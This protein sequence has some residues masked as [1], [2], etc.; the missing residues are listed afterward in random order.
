[1]AVGIVGRRGR[2][3][4]ASLSTG[5]ELLLFTLDPAAAARASADGVDGIVV[6]WESVGKP[7]RQAGAD[8]Q[9]EPGSVDDLAAVRAATR[10]RVLCRVNG[11]GSWT[12]D[13]VEG[14]IDAGADELLLPMVRTVEEAAAFVELVGGRCSAGLLVETSAAVD[15][16]PELARLPLSRVYVGLNDLAIDRGAASIFSAVVD[17]TV[18]RIRRAF[19]MPFGFGGLTLPELGRPIPCLLL[20]AE[21]ARLGCDFSFLRRSYHADIGGRDPRVELPRIRASLAAAASRSP[22]AVARDRRRL[23]ETVARAEAAPEAA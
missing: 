23:A 9:I 13:E 3:E 8:T 20:I 7:E 16:A 18:E 10:A 22:S 4:G 1:M 21:M 19:P 2:P 14:A 12:P 5:F 15:C 17:G 6:D 11:F